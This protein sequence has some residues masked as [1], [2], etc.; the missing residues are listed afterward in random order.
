VRVASGDNHPQFESAN[1]EIRLHGE[2]GRFDA[3]QDFLVGWSVSLCY[4]FA[5]D[6]EVLDL[7]EVIVGVGKTHRGDFG[8]LKREVAKKVRSMRGKN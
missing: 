8:G 7:G 5:V 1:V 3:L 2:I 6:G 4:S